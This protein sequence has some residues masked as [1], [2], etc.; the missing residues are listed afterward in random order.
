MMLETRDLTVKYDLIS[1][2]SEV[3]IAAEALPDR[4]IIPK[5]ALLERGEGMRRFLVLVYETDEN[6]EGVGR[7][8]Y[9]NPGR[10]NATHVEILAE[11]PETGMIEPGEIV[12]VDGH[13]FLG[14]GVPVTLVEDDGN[15]GEE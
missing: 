15:G 6:G 8:R 12:L 14:D 7:Y 10:E 13:H 5:A 9:V 3:S 1:A 11:G 4:I 2:L